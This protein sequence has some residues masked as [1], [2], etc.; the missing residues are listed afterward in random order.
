MSPPNSAA[1]LKPTEHHRV[2]DFVSEAG[3]DVSDWPNYRR[4]EH[5]ASN[6]KNC[7]NWAFGGTDRVVLCL[8]HEEMKQDESGADGRMKKTSRGIWEIS[9]AGRGG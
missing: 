7:Y 5:P 2:Y 9:T 6:P 4:S 8:W 3:L 1:D